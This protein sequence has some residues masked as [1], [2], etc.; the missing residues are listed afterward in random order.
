MTEHVASERITTDGVD[1]PEPTPSSRVGRRRW[2]ILVLAFLALVVL[3]RGLLVETFYVPSGSMEPTLS[4]GDRIAVWK[5]GADDVRRGDVVVFNGTKAF[6]PSRETSEPSGLSKAV[7]SVGDALGFRSGESDYVKRVI[8]VGG[9]RVRMDSAGKV[10]VND[11]AI[12]EPYA[13]VQSAGPPFD[14]AVPSGRLWVMG[15]NR[16]QSDDSRGHLGDPG[17]GTVKA[18]DVVG[19]VVGRYWP[20]T[21]VGGLPSDA[22]QDRGGNHD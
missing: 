13:R 17:G 3:T 6:G 5:P 11:T 22:A 10:F 4:G 9:D 16:A 15:D 8:A 2:P 21:D 19:K 20:L 14:V 12:T 1:S 18:D 7:R